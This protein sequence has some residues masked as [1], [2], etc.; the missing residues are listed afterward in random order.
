MNEEHRD[1][2]TLHWVLAIIAVILLVAC[3]LL[4]FRVW[5]DSPRTAP[6]PVA[7]GATSAAPTTVTATE[8]ITANAK[9]TTEQ[10]KKAAI[11]IQ[12]FR[13]GLQCDD[14]DAWSYAAHFDDGEVLICDGGYYL[15]SFGDAPWRAGAPLQLGDGEFE[16]ITGATAIHLNDGELTVTNK[17]V[18]DPSRTRKTNEFYTYNPETEDRN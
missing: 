16:V 11:S 15:D 6:P 14:G 12:G 9:H 8:T 7:Q 17:G 5:G 13:D 18:V 1:N 3:A 10:A 2:R 4:A